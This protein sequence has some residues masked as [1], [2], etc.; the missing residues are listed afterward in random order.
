MDL[1]KTISSLVEKYGANAT[2][3][4]VLYE[5]GQ[6]LEHEAF[7][8][9]MEEDMQYMGEAV[10]RSM[11]EDPKTSADCLELIKTELSQRP[12]KTAIRLALLDRARFGAF[13]VPSFYDS[14]EV[15]QM[16]KD[17]LEA[18]KKVM[19]LRD[20]KDMEKEICVYENHRTRPAILKLFEMINCKNMSCSLFH[21]EV[22]TLVLARIL[23]NWWPSSSLPLNY[24]P[25]M[26]DSSV[27]EA[28][29]D[30]LSETASIHHT[31]VADILD[32]IRHNVEKVCSRCG[33][34]ETLF[35]ASRAFKADPVCHAYICAALALALRKVVAAVGV[36][37]ETNRVHYKKDRIVIVHGQK[38]ILPFLVHKLKIA[39]HVTDEVREVLAF[40]PNTDRIGE[41]FCKTKKAFVR[42]AAAF[43]PN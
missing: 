13:H 29:S 18:H 21:K 34:I 19:R 33:N 40:F 26:L 10:L 43:L 41:A 27:L 15:S 28:L 7:L 9:A 37:P 11:L 14:P 35:K 3:E 5:E 30:F 16:K 36:N 6:S 20:Y 12:R 31:L 25:V 1:L 42:D 38:D 17:A 39:T 4:D 2:L 23:H 8:E 22:V 32:A 24:S